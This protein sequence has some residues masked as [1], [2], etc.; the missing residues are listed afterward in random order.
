MINH[1]PTPIPS[2]RRAALRRTP[3]AFPPSRRVLRPRRFVGTVLLAAMALSASATAQDAEDDFGMFLPIE[4]ELPEFSGRAARELTGDPPVVRARRVALD[5]DAF[6]R[7]GAMLDQGQETPLVRLNLFPDLLVESLVEWRDLTATGYSWSGGVESDPAGSVAMAVNGDALHGIVRTRGR[8]FTIRRAADGEYAIRELDRSRLPAGAAPLPAPRNVTVDPPAPGFIDDPNRVDVAVFYTTQARTDAG[9]DDEIHALIDAWVADTNAAYLR[10]D[11]HH[12][13]NL[14]LRQHVSYKEATDTEDRS[15]AGQALDC[16]QDDEDGCLDVD[17]IRDEY[18]ADLVHLLISTGVPNTACGIAFLTGDYGVSELHCGSDTFAH[19]IGHNSGVNHD[20]YQEYDEDCETDS[21][22]PCF[23]EWPSAYAY[24]Y[25]NQLGLASTAP[26]ERRWRTVM[27]YHAQCSDA[28]VYCPQLMRF[29]NPSQSWYGDKLG[30]AGTRGPSSYRDAADAAKRG[31]ADA[32]RTHREF[33]HD[34]ANRTVRKAPDLVVKGFRPTRSQAEPGASV[35]LTA[36]VE[37][38]GI[39]TGPTTDT[40]VTWCRATRSTC[41]SASPAGTSSTVPELAANDRVA[42]STSFNAPRATGAYE[43]RAC[44][45]RAPGETLIKNNCSEPVNI[46]VGVVDLRF[47]MSLSPSSVQAGAE[48]RIQGAVRNHGTLRSSAGRIM[49]VKQDSNGDPELVGSGSFSALEPGSS[50]TFETTFDAPAVAGSHRYYTCL[51]STHVEWDC[52]SASLTVTGPSS[53]GTWSMSGTGNAIVE[54]P[55]DIRFIRIQGEYSGYS[56]NFI[57]WCGRYA[58][59]GG[60]LVNELL[61]TGW[62]QTRYSGVHSAL[63]S[64][65]RRGDPCRELEIEESEGVRWTINDSPG[66]ASLSSPAG[67]G[68]PAADLIA[69]QEA[70]RRH[71]RVQR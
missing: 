47:S 28:E 30:V 70:I 24:G 65:N 18:S 64:Y 23:D 71:R 14:V 21:A 10:S 42:V 56:S 49:F 40:R 53:G 17:D 55:T 38:L 9:G 45:S 46:D 12:R 39:S 66:G 27:A 62:G 61:G 33:A 32:A 35:T 36:I 1:V 13:L 43:Y 25:V 7:L 29:S 50:R 37:N 68:N 22:V 16:F 51:S 52:V 57:V 54:L 8:V 44:A 5:L 6:A 11:I 34:L 63:R 3:A 60:L 20:R 15:A 69:V 31:P 48:V 4:G 2:G 67:T 58:D 59:A 19:E 26:V 41:A